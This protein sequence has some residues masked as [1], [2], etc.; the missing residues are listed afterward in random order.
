MVSRSDAR[1]NLAYSAIKTDY[2]LY[3][4]VTDHFL[5]PRESKRCNLPSI[6]ACVATIIVPTAIKPPIFAKKVRAT[7]LTLT[8]TEKT[9]LKGA[10][11]A[12]RQS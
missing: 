2:N 9:L 8:S 3:R 7:D 12:R 4:S 5:F 6:G 10:D 11:K 1:R